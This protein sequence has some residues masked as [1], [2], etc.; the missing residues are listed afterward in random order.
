MFDAHCHLD[1]MDH[2]AAWI[3]ARNA[4]VQDVLI[5]GVDAEGWAKQ[6]AIHDSHTHVA[7]G[8]HPW[9]VAQRSVDETKHQ[10]DQLRQMLAAPPVQ[11]IALGETGLDYSNRIPTESRPNQSV[12]F[13]QHIQLAKEY[14]LPLILHIVRA[15]NEA[16]S[17][18]KQE[19]LPP[20]GG[21]VHS[22]SGS[23]EIAH[24]YI[25]IGL[26]ISFSGTVVDE[27][28]KGVQNAAQS[29]PVDRMLVETDS[30]DQTPITRRP[31]SNEP[32]FLVDVINAVATLR[33]EDFGTVATYTR[34]NAC[35]LFKLKRP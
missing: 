6:N 24:Q 9:A 22:F 16:L 29:I 10:M 7:W 32:A 1:R 14:D 28:R 21:M 34:R 25:D 2:H 35:L 26:H 27:R 19:G 23:K 31:S 15:H 18:L 20:S 12:I 8:L 30:P 17:I 33:G 4:G 5:A 11:P 3:R 13:R